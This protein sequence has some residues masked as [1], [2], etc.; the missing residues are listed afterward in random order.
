MVR[1]DRF[2]RGLE[3]RADA[4]GHSLPSDR[5]MH[6]VELQL[7]CK[8]H[9]EGERPIL[10]A[11]WIESHL[12]GFNPVQVNQRSNAA[13]T[14]QLP[15][16]SGRLRYRLQC[17][18]CRNAPVLRQQT[19]EGWL[20]RIYERGAAPKVLAGHP[21]LAKVLDLGLTVLLLALA[22]RLSGQASAVTRVLWGL[23]LG[24]A[25]G[26]A[27][28]RVGPAGV[29]DWLRVAGY[30]AAFNLADL[31]VR[32]AAV[33]LAI[34]LLGRQSGATRRDER[35]PGGSASTREGAPQPAP[36]QTEPTCSHDRRD[37]DDGRPRPGLLGVQ[38]SAD[39][40][41]DD[42]REGEVGLPTLI[43]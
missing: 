35:L 28:D 31:F 25:L 24:G 32:L 38:D 20:A 3:P 11:W 27:A 42:G 7:V 13:V 4:E 8:Q 33:G 5:S 18:K 23:L 29:V 19:I 1:G 6:Y 26:N 41:R 30:P 37:D 15:D 2:A 12:D 40:R 9:P 17:P 36:D 10:G 22:M 39:A 34:S 21:A 43:G 14:T 16:G